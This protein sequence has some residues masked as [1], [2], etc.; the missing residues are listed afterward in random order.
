MP[1]HIL[2]TRRTR[3]SHRFPSLVCPSLLKIQS[4]TSYLR[5]RLRVLTTLRLP[6]PHYARRR[7][8]TMTISTAVSLRLL[9]T[10]RRIKRPPP[11]IKHHRHT[12][13]CLPYKRRNNKQLVLRR[14]MAEAILQMAPLNLH[15]QRIRLITTRP[16]LALLKQR[17]SHKERSF[18]ST[19]ETCHRPHIRCLAGIRILAS[20]PS[21]IAQVR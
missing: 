2:A 19:Q 15:L 1:R 13:T 3:I 10:N 16:L 8:K 6:P 11:I 7:R 5:T 4:T 17:E 12:P 9:P 20:L 14:T 18:T 21:L